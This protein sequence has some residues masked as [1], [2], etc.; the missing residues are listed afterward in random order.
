MY[1]SGLKIK[2]FNRVQDIDGRKNK[3]QLFAY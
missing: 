3:G 2:V 1:L